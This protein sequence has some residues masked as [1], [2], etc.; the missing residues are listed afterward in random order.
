MKTICLLLACFM[1]LSLYSQGL[2]INEVVSKN[3]KSLLTLDGSSPDWMELY[4]IS[5]DTISLFNY[6]LSDNSEDL[7]KWALPNIKLEPNGFLIVFASGDDY[8]DES[9][10]HT[11]F[12]IKGDGEE[13]LL[14]KQNGD[15]ID[16]FPAVPLD[17]NKSFGRY[18]DGIFYSGFLSSSSAGYSNFPIET[19]FSNISF[20]KE[21]GVYA[22]DFQLGISASHPTAKIYYT[23]DGSDPLPSSLLYTDSIYINSKSN[24]AN[25]ISE[26]PTSK[27]WA[28]P[29]NRVFKGNII[30]AAAFLNG[31]AISQVFT[32]SYFILPESKKP[33]NFPIVSLSTD[34]KNLFSPDSGIYIAGNNL[35]YKRR[36]RQWERTTS[37]EYFDETGN[38]NY[39][40][41]IGVRAY[42]NKG[43]TL[44]QKSLL[45]YARE[46]YGQNR[47]KYS[48]FEDKNT[49]SFKRLILRSASSNDWKNTLF[50]NEL[51]QKITANLG[52][53]HPSSIAVIVFVNGEYWGIHHLAE[54]TD[55]FYLEDYYNLEKGEIDFLSS[56]S[57]VEEGSAENYA[58][59]KNFI[60]Q[61]DLKYESNFEYVSTQIDITNFIDYNCA[62]LF[63]SNTDWPNNNIKYWKKQNNGKWNWLFFDCDD[64]MNYEYY[65]LI[66]DFLN[67]EN[68]RLDFPKWSTFLLHNLMKNEN[69]KI[70]FRSRF[71]EL[72][73]NDFSFQNTKKH[74][75]EMKAIYLPEVEEHCN[76][77]STPANSADWKEAVNSLYSFAA[78]R[79]QIVKTQLEDYF[80]NPFVLYPNPA[81]NN[82]SLDLKVEASSFKKMSITNVSGQLVYSIHESY[83]NP[84]DLP[85][86]KAGVYFVEIV[87][88]DNAYFEKLIIN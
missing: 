56:N 1:N 12:K 66:G 10:L 29:K 65:N 6:F 48:F 57:I 23:T 36:G 55:E 50:K 58:A 4:N 77:W 3:E 38:F 83:D 5:S 70:I 21:A 59:L 81:K 46:D 53:E 42:G 19:E 39:Y 88:Q 78:L 37:F 8:F 69:F 86:L 34:N 14:S 64:C 25:N 16:S 63:F 30:K 45:L 68:Y 11:N 24:T 33:Y 32:K 67:A 82:I 43:R 60:I 28:A 51:T 54:R 73:N 75:D 13:I 35:N 72:L 79:P 18:P 31:I 15:I 47:F 44:P 62:E 40:Q 76:R 80:Q 7:L 27:S 17:V 9:E 2:V 61:N 22:N 41:K 71:E 26:I 49:N 20:S 84:I 87:L 85:L 52:F 74:I